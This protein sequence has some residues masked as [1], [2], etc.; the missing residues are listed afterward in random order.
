MMRVRWRHAC[1]AGILSVY[2]SAGSAQTL[3]PDQQLV[4]S[5]YKEL[6]E[7]NT[8]ESAGSATQAAQ[9]MATRLRAAGYPAKDVQILSPAGNPRKGNLVARLRG[10]GAL[11]PLLLL[12]H[13][14]V[15]EARREDWT[16][17]PFTLVEENGFFYARGAADDKSMAAVFVAEMIRLKR[18]GFTPARDIVLALTADEELGNNSEY[19]GVEFLLRA[20]RNLIDAELA[21]N[22]GGGGRIGPDGKYERLHVQVAE[23]VYQDFR[24][25]ITDP[26]GHSSVPKADNPIYRMSEALLRVGRF[27]FP[28]KLT[29]STRAFFERI[30]KL[31][32]GQVAAD[33]TAI[34]QDPPDAA[35]VDRL[36]ASPDTNAQLRTTCVATMLE[37]GHAPN[38][39]PQRVRATVNCRIIPG[40]RI[41]DVEQ[42]LSSA[43]GDSRITITPIGRESTSAP[44]P[45]AD[46]VM[47]PIEEVT[48]SMWPGVPVVPTMSA[49]GTDGRF[50]NNAGIHTYGVSGMFNVA[51]SN[52]HGLNERLRV[53]ALYE[54]QDFLYRLIKLL[55]G[56]ARAPGVGQ[57][58]TPG[59]R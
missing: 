1:C 4:R 7:I 34:L 54:G 47:K 19:N 11:R 42:A 22:E 17:D 39:L 58:S 51:D 26:G 8:T 40:E 41:R 9:A 24:L 25:Q 13:T 28:A 27:Q 53:A 46:N 38:A 32:S 15:V 5:I 29:E 10:T 50:L 14:D 20:H 36:S 45:L 55:S 48:A 59:A 57:L 31:S 3:T 52:T 21:L 6:I 23:K 56:A 30:S 18:E 43:I 35:A 49:G 44:S 33:M 37:G 12:A 16:R 2:A